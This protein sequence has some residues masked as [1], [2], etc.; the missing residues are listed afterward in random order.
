MRYTYATKTQAIADS[1]RGKSIR[2]RVPSSEMS[3]LFLSAAAVVTLGWNNNGGVFHQGTCAWTPTPVTVSLKKS[4]HSQMH[5]PSATLLLAKKRPNSRDDADDMSSWYDPVDEN[6]TPDQVFFQEMERQRLINQVGGSDSM[7]PSLD[8]IG[9]VGNGAAATLTPMNKPT[10]PSALR[11]SGAAAPRFATKAPPLGTTTGG[12]REWGSSP[13]QVPGG[14]DAPPPM[15]RRKVPTMIQIQVAE[16]TLSEYEAFMVSDNWLNEELQEKMW[17]GGN[18]SSN[19][20]DGDGF[21]PSSGKDGSETANG[22][23]EFTDDGKSEPW[24]D[25]GG[26]KKKNV[27][28]DRRNIME[29]P[30]PSKGAYVYHL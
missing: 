10:T 6:A 30:F 8:D 17:D 7:T 23:S 11:S 18:E 20:R 25:F 22:E 9:K 2:H 24:D 19:S 13:P 5:S 29:V 27:D 26:E 16:A 15:R 14:I 1:T 4:P 28:Y 12:G 3:I 21:S